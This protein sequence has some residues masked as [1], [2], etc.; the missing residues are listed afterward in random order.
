MHA[1]LALSSLETSSSERLLYHWASCISSYNEYLAP[2]I[3]AKDASAML[4]TSTLISGIAFAMVDD[5]TWPSDTNPGELQWL[6]LQQGISLVFMSIDPFD[7]RGDIQVLFTGVEEI[8]EAAATKRD[9][10]L[11]FPELFAI[12]SDPKE[13]PYTDALHS[14][15]AFAYVPVLPSTIFA[16]LGFIAS[17]SKPFTSLL[18]AKDHRALLILAYWYARMCAI[19]YWWI[20]RRAKSECRAICQYLEKYAIFEIQQLLVLPAKVC[21][22]ELKQQ[23]PDDDSAGRIDAST[24]IPCRPM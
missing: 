23:A 5:T 15:A 13:N 22:Y 18:E 4:I 7:L 24:Y 2:K 17:L 3:A 20:L 21:G 10:S 14:L 8:D 11:A 1:L 9:P 6:R 19:D 16:H 12:T